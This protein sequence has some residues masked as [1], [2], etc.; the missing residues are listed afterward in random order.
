MLHRDG[1]ASPG[2]AWSSPDGKPHFPPKA[3]S[4]IWLFMN[5]GVSHVETFDPKP[6]L[7]KYAA[8]PIAG[9]PSR[10]AQT[11]KSPRLARSTVV[12]TANAQQRTR[13]T[14]LRAGVGRRAEGRVRPDRQAE[15]AAGGGV[16]RRPGPRRPDQVVR[17]GV[18]DAEV[19]PRGARL[20]EGDRG[21]EEALRPGS[22]G[23]PRVRD[24]VAR[25]T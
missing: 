6:M 14:R 23:D 24:A 13:L 16:P 1:F 5:G 8:K 25:L 20:L 21:D 10:E 18:P 7:T 9:S 12:K 3:K 15:Q 4:V 2:T 11:P 22:A 17:A 19:A